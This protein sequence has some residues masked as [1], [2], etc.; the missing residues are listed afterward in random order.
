M[1]IKKE[2][3]KTTNENEKKEEEEEEEEEEEVEKEE[4]KSIKSLQLEWQSVYCH[5]AHGSVSIF[6]LVGHYKPRNLI[7]RPLS[8]SL[9]LSLS[10]NIT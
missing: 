3:K 4:K 8:L 5:R 2:P 7:K 6:Y 1:K 9:S 10:F